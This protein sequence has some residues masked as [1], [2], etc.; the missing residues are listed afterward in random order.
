[1]SVVTLNPNKPGFLD[2]DGRPLWIHGVNYEGF[3]DRAWAMWKPD[4][5]DPGLIAHDF[6]KARAS[7]FNSVRLF[8][9][10]ENVDE[11]NSGNFTRLD[12]VFNLACNNGLYVL[13]SV[14]RI[15]ASISGS[16]SN[17]PSILSDAAS[18]T[19]FTVIPRS[20]G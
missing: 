9:Q 1:M 5:Y 12:T 11:I 7:G 10:K 3:Y 17:L 6:Q 2:P 13:L 14:M 20:A 16:S 15:A 18:S 8:I 4:L 19:S